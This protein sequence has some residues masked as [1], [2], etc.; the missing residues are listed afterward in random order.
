[1]ERP[2]L[3]SAPMVNAI[4][5]GLKTQTRRV[6]RVTDAGCKPGFVT[7]LCGHTPRS[8]REHEA[9]C[10]Y[11]RPGDRLWVR[12]KW[13]HFGNVSSGRNPVRANVSYAADGATAER[14]E[15]KNFESAPVRAW[16]NTGKTPWAPSIHMPRW[17]SRIT[18][19]LTGVR[20]E[21]LAGISW[22]DAVAEGWPGT[23]DGAIRWFRDLWNS[24]NSARKLGWAVNPWVWV[25]EFRRLSEQ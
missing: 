25:L 13:R 21:Q 14:G 18:L 20:V 23:E 17:A 10:P 15:W 6:A 9:Y 1:M 19:E 11:G 3:F 7:P 24:V 5:G 8:L 4:L 12:E 22:D 2:I 16:W